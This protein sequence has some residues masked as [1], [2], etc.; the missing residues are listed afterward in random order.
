[1]D[2][3]HSKSSTSRS[4]W[5]VTLR[6]KIITAIS[7]HRLSQQAPNWRFTLRMSIARIVHLSANTKDASR[8][9]SKRKTW[10]STCCVTPKRKTSSV[11]CVIK[12]RS[13]HNID[14]RLS[15]LSCP[16]FF[17][18][19]Q[20]FTTTRAW[21]PIKSFILET[22]T[23]RVMLAASFSSPNKRLSFIICITTRHRHWNAS[24]A[25]KCKNSWT[26]KKMSNVKWQF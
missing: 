14:W 7:V 3:A 10:R 12:V 5:S 15:I 23:S 19:F 8:R 17:F 2:Y 16:S 13:K 26:S 11:W 6:S 25:I 21:R 18:C 1:M 20:L 24:S 9:S 4:I 22:R